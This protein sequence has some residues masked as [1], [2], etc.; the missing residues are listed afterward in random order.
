MLN[1]SICSQEE[2]FRLQKEKEEAVSGLSAPPPNPTPL[3]LRPEL[4]GTVNNDAQWN[5]SGVPFAN[6]NNNGVVVGDQLPSFG[7]DGFQ[8]PSI[9][10][11]L[12]LNESL[13]KIIEVNSLLI[14]LCLAF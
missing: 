12:A 10:D 7:F 2:N 6:Q 1:L 8:A 4:D 3:L 11:L 14:C 9:P 13:N 5:N